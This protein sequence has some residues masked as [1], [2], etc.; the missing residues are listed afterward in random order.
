MCHTEEDGSH[1]MCRLTCDILNHFFLTDGKLTN[2]VAEQCYILCQWVEPVLAA[3]KCANPQWV[4]D[5]LSAAPLES[6]E[7]LAFFCAFCAP[8]FWWFVHQY[9]LADHARLRNVSASPVYHF[10]LCSTFITRLMDKISL[11]TY[12]WIPSKPSGLLILQSSGIWY[13]VFYC[14]V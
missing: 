5:R 10:V 8:H 7:H 1:K 11:C 4:A 2:L 6:A 13:M 3:L 9:V 12:S 14:Y